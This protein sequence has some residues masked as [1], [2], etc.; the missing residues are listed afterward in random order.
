LLLHLLHLRLLGMVS[1]TMSVE[2]FL[3]TSSASRRYE[4][5]RF[6]YCAR[7]SGSRSVPARVFRVKNTRTINA[8][9]GFQSFQLSR[10]ESGL[11]E[12]VRQMPQEFRSTDWKYRIKSEQEKCQGTELSTISPSIVPE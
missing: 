2:A 4:S 12:V 9:G 11:S 7:K 6:S 8:H 5:A 1:Y 10:M 3:A